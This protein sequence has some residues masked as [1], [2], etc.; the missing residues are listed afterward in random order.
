MFLNLQNFLTF[1]NNTYRQ[2][3]IWLFRKRFTRHCHMWKFDSS[4]FFLNHTSF[5]VDNQLLEKHCYIFCSCTHGWDNDKGT[6]VHGLLNALLL[7]FFLKCICSALKIKKEAN[8][9]SRPDYTWTWST[10]KCRKGFASCHH[11]L[12]QYILDKKGNA[13]VSRPYQEPSI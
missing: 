11:R 13:F 9:G 7:L 3:Y 4:F 8:Q 5:Y 12:F 1:K 6:Q 2:S 10:F